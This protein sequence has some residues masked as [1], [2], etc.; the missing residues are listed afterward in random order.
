M[1]WEIGLILSTIIGCVE[2]LLLVL[3]AIL[4][5][6]VLLFGFWTQPSQL[7]Q[8]RFFSSRQVINMGQIN[9]FMLANQLP[10]FVFMLANQLP[11]FVQPLFPACLCLV[12]LLFICSCRFQ[13]IHALFIQGTANQYVVLA[14]GSLC[15]NSD[16]ILQLLQSGLGC[17][18]Y[19]GNCC[20]MHI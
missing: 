19:A 11:F 17:L 5:M 13:L 2:Y 1:V 20:L 8:S 12:S 6:G 4:F 3:L 9:V 14:S 7:S 16:R 18:W 15:L 10:F